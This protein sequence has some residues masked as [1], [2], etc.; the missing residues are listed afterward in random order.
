MI[1]L[2]PDFVGHPGCFQAL[3]P[4]L[5]P[6]AVSINYHALAQE[7]HFPA[8][9]AQIAGQLAEAPAWII[10]YSF[11]GA[12]GYELCRHFFPACRLV[13]VD[14]HLPWPALRET[15]ADEQYQRWLTPETRDWIALMQEL[16]EI[17]LPVILNN[18]R[19]F[20]H[21]QPQPALEHAWW[22]RCDG[23]AFHASPDWQPLIRRVQCVETSARHHEVMK[24][25]GVISYLTQ[26]T[27]EVT[28]P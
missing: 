24:A 22:I 2:L 17:S 10:G 20:S 16:G 25:P 8:L 28:L 26:L 19:L 5:P 1:L 14:S 12:L 15:P 6:Q 21:W 7:T 11:G 3:L 4:H 9:A 23:E 13:M 18:I 27:Q